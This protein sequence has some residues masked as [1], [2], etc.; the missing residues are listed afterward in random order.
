LSPAPSGNSQAD[1]FRPLRLP[2]LLVGDY[3]LGGIGTTISAYESLKL[4]GYDIQLHLMFEEEEYQNVKY[5]SD[6]FAGRG[7]PTIGL[8][9]PPKLVKDAAEDLEAMWSYY[10]E[11]TA[12]DSI[13]KTLDTLR[14]THKDRISRLEE[15]PAK[16]EANFWYP[17]TQHQ[18]RT[19]KDIM[20]I[21]S[22]YQD[23]FDVKSQ[24]TDQTGSILQ[25]AFDG[26]A[27]WWT[28][29]LG[30]G[31]PDL[32]LAAAYAAGRYGHVMF[33]GTVHEPALRLTELLLEYHQNPRLAKV[34]FTD[35]GSTGMEVALKMALRASSER[36][37]WDH[38][39]HDIEILGF[40]G[41]YHGDT[42][43]VMDC[44]EPSTYNEK[45]EWYRPRGCEYL[46]SRI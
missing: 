25:P 20:V 19:A 11:V 28:Q 1:L 5:L 22:A 30:H 17:F 34:F 18:G 14:S 38:H 6:Y 31:N 13:Y 33:A 9:K 35:N 21:D 40:K 3:H 36:Y 45:V 44:A 4:R 42:M 29:G 32:S 24:S 8:P 27:S 37:G 2:T 39:S 41:S 16:A 7:I 12:L 26:S 23:S 10:Q 15:M 46:F 43:G